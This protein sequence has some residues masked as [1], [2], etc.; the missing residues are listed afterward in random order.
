MPP[1]ELMQ[2]CEE[3][4]NARARQ[5]KHSQAD[6]APHLLSRSNE[7]ITAAR[8]AMDGKAVHLFRIE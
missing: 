5:L 6:N 3:I 1:K 7:A 4:Y 2:M 8:L